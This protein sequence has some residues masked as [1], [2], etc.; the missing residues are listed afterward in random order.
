MTD[1]RFAHVG[2]PEDR[3]IEEC[4]ELIQAVTKAK[5][6]GWFNHHPDHPGRTNHEDVKRE[7]DDVTEAI[8]RL[9]IQMR[10]ISL[11]HFAEE[12]PR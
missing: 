9:S 1:P 4:A 2:S 5:R 10:F 12:P 7:M 3:L 8:E 11:A 6:F